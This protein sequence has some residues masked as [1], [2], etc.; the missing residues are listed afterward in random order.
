MHILRRPHRAQ[1]EDDNGGYHAAYRAGRA[2]RAIH[3]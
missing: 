3:G 1:Q 2:E